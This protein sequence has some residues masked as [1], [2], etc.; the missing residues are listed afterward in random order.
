MIL[1]Y[2]PYIEIP[3]FW[4]KC[5]SDGSVDRIRA[6]AGLGENG[7]IHG[8]LY[9]KQGDDFSYMIGYF[10][11]QSDLPEG[12]EKLQIPAQTYAIFSTR[13][14]P[15]GQSNIHDLWKRIFLEWFPNSNYEN[16]NAPEFEMTYDRGNNMS[17]ME[18]WIPIVK[19]PVS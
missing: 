18:I 10:P 8:I 7:Q 11:P 14:Y 4:T 5:I 13:V 15:D 3:A 1:S 12:F 19:K 9:N 2:F 16:A 17:E 6:A